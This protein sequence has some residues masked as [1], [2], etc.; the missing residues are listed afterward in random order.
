MTKYKTA[1][2]EGAL[3]DAAVAKADSL[4]F[5]LFETFEGWQVSRS[6]WSPDLGRWAPSTRWEQGGPLIESH[7]IAIIPHTYSIED[8]PGMAW[9][10]EGRQVVP[11]SWGPTPLVAA[12]RALVCGVLGTEV[13]LPA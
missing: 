3:L 7:G 13:E 9:W 4:P 8:A 5:H 1:K 12:M 6:D 2:L 10:A 11:P